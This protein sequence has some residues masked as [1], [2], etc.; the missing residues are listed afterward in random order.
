MWAGKLSYDISIPGRSY[1]M[2]STLPVTF[3]FLPI[4][5]GLK[6]RS[7]V[8]TLKEY[9][10]LSTTQ[11][12]S[13]TVARVVKLHRDTKF[14]ETAHRLG[15]AFHKTEELVIPDETSPWIMVDTTNALISVK[16]KL[17]ITVSL[18]NADGHISGK[19]KPPPIK[20]TPDIYAKRPF[21]ELRAAIPIVIVTIPEDEDAL[22]TYE[23]AWR[24]APY[25]PPLVVSSLPI[26]ATPSLPDLVQPDF[27]K[28]WL[29]S[30]PSSASSS[31]SSLATE[32]MDYHPGVDLS[33]VP[34]YGT[35]LRSRRPCSDSLPTYESISLPQIYE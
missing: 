34:S 29:S 17:K 11:G 4:H 5:S 30:G 7:V 6:I 25:H 9:L 1:T 31:T 22:P 21:L 35:A 24:S 26:G 32:I 15:P 18:T 16:H 14:Q 19:R 28:P 13:K 27:G 10:T 2:G 8:C 23:N 3:D 12:Y 20:I 33:R